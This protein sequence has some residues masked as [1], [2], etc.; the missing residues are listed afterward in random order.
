MNHDRTERVT[1]ARLERYIHTHGMLGILGD[2][3]LGS[4][5]F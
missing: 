2:A 4:M 3:L 5:G 1:E